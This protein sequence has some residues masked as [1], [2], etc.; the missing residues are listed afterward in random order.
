M[1]EGINSV[2]KTLQKFVARHA[3][4]IASVSDETAYGDGYWI[5]LNDGW[6]DA[7][8]PQCHTLHENTIAE[9]I[10]AFDP[11]PCNC[12]GCRKAEKK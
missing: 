10:A 8:N 12:L 6:C 3:D 11:V 9:L 1:I 4:K 5:A 2:P 7:F